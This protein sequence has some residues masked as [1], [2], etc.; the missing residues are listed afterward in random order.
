MGPAQ[1]LGHRLVLILVRNV[2]PGLDLSDL[3]RTEKPSRSQQADVNTGQSVVVNFSTLVAAMLTRFI[4]LPAA[5][6]KLNLQ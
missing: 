4:H 1:H 5:T 3:L 2:E 6:V